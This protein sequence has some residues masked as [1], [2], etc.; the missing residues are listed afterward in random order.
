MVARFR[1]VRPRNRSSLVIR[2]Q[3]CFSSSENSDILGG[4]P[5]FAKELGISRLARETDHSLPSVRQ[6]VDDLQS[7]NW[8]LQRAL[9]HVTSFLIS[10]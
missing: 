8:L 2:A 7:V 9:K 1:A 6:N 3:I 5:A 10:Y 4:H